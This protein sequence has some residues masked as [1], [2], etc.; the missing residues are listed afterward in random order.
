MAEVERK[1]DALMHATPYKASSVPREFDGVPGVYLFSEDGNPLY[2]GRADNIRRRLHNH[3]HR[4]HNTATFAFLLAR[5]DTGIR[6]ATYQP[7]GSRS[8]LLKNNAHFSEAFDKARHRIAQMEVQIVREADP[9]KQAL[10][11]IYSA[12]VCGAKYNDFKNH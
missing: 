7:T 10:L 2:I 4:S 11:E 12:F 5:H 9:V 3:R 8:D 6:E 1:Y